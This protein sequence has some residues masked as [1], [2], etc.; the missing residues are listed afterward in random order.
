MNTPT[1]RHI[2]KERK[3]TATFTKSNLKV[4]KDISFNFGNK[5][6]SFSTVPT[7][8]SGRSAVL[9]QRHSTSST[10]AV[11]KTPLMNRKSVQFQNFSTGIK[12]DRLNQTSGDLRYV[13]SFYS[14]W[15]LVFKLII[16]ELKILYVLANRILS[17]LYYKEKW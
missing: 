1:E 15:W 5:K 7:R 14:R 3:K 6:P 2:L 4:D 17:Y 11:K 9:K 12:V 13:F 10:A 8:L 16:L